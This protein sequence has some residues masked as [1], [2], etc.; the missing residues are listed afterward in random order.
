MAQAPPTVEIPTLADL[1][2]RLGDVAPDRILMQP[3]LGT[4]TRQ[5]LIALDRMGEP[6]YEL[7][8]GVIVRKAMG[9][10]ES[11]IGVAISTLLRN[12]VAG[13]DL[14]VVSGADGMMELGVNLIR[15]ADV[16]FVAWEKFPQGKLSDDPAPEIAPDLAVEVLSR[17]NTPREMQRKRVDFFGAGTRLVWI[18]DPKQRTVRVYTDVETF[19][20]FSAEQKL[21]GGEVLP[22]FE[23]AV[24]DIFADLERA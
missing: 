9:Y 11:I 1:L 19:E 10:L 23:V 13:K 20:E 6:L 24:R 22:G 17:G 3:P 18:V 8:D 4:A 16:A 15:M 14:G 2:E 7:I 5:D 12:F 21:T